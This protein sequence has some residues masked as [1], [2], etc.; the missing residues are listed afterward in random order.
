M[1]NDARQTDQDDKNRTVLSETKAKQGGF[2]QSV[3][4]WIMVASLLLAGIAGAA[5][6]FMVDEE[7]G[8]TGVV[9]ESTPDSGTPA[10]VPDGG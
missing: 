6:V 2:P 5:L 10:A 3:T 4:L 1:T 7:T 8:D 9:L